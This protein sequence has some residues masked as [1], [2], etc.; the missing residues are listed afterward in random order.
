[1]T[2]LKEALLGAHAQTRSSFSSFSVSE[3]NLRPLPLATTIERLL[4]R[5]C[6]TISKQNI[7][8]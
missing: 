8:V 6:T 3:I 1:M 7:R 4:L 5:H 2:N